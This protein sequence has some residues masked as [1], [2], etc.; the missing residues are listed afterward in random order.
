MASYIKSFGIFFLFFG[1]GLSAFFSAFEKNAISRDPAALNGKVY[2]IT[3]LTSEQIRSQLQKK[4]KVSPTL[5]GKKAIQFSGFSSA[6]CK[7]YPSISIE[8]AAEGIAVA[9]EAP[10]M[11]ITAPCTEG[12][13][14]AEIASINLAITKI[15][16]EKPRDAEYTFDGFNG[17]VTFKN[18]SDEWP[19]QWILKRVEF[20]NLQGENKAAEFNRAPASAGDAPAEKP[21]VLEF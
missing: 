1:L 7:T 17:V 14:P 18:S 20:K 16:N 5:D 8:F 11:K 10:T 3:N 19:R 12:Q 4:I 2:Q 9:G 21:I 6:L 15:L 13:D